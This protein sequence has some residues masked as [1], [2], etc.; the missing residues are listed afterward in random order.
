MACIVGTNSRYSDTS[1]RRCQC[2]GSCLGRVTVSCSHARGR[3]SESASLESGC[4]AASG[5]LAPQQMTSEHG[6]DSGNPGPPWPRAR[7][8]ASLLPPCCRPGLPSLPAALQRVAPDARCPM[9]EM[10]APRP[11]CS[12]RR[13]NTMRPVQSTPAAPGGPVVEPRLA[14]SEMHRSFALDFVLCALCAVLRMV[15]RHPGLDRT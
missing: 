6:T 4:T 15:H 10:S 1:E 13:P 11:M 12:H 2:L 5:Q 8:A 3:V 7:P 14:S 9:P